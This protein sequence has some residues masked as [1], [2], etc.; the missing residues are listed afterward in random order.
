MKHTKQNRHKTATTLKREGSGRRPHLI[1]V[2]MLMTQTV[3]TY[4]L[5]VPDIVGKTSSL[6]KTKVS[7]VQCK[8]KGKLLDFLT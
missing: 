7:L 5:S 4:R 8:L 1:M 2:E 3:N 6:K